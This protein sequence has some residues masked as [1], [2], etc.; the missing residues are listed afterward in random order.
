M[1]ASPLHDL[2]KIGI[3][4]KIL[5]KPGK[6]TDE[7]QYVMRNHT[8]IGAEILK[9]SQSKVMKMAMIV[10][11]SHHEKWDGSGFPDSLSGENIPIEGR[12]V[13]ICDV[14][15]ALISSR[16]Y[17]ESWTEAEAIDFLRQSSGTHFDPNLVELFIQNIPQIKEFSCRL[18]A[19][20]CSAHLQPAAPES[21]TR[22]GIMR[23]IVATAE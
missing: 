22:S 15:D 6:L 4:D 11:F 23:L 19:L 17:K 20:G 3:P 2:G 10:A 16:H 14:F 1:H 9:P 13:A 12:I 8:R 21:I 7:E 18:E 5:L